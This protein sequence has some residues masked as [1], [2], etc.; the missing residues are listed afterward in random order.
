MA[1]LP[2]FKNMTNKHRKRLGTFKNINAKSI[3]APKLSPIRKTLR[4]RAANKGMTLSNMHRIMN[5]GNTSR[6]TRRSR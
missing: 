6:R 3:A 1:R 5:S 4:Q 2:F